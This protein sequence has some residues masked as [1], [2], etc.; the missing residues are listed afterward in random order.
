MSEGDLKELQDEDVDLGVRRRVEYEDDEDGT[1]AL[2]IPKREGGGEIEIPLQ[3]HARTVFERT[4]GSLQDNTMLAVRPLAEVGR[5]RPV[6]RSGVTTNTGIATAML[7]P[8]YLYVFLDNRLWRELE[9]GTDGKLSDVDLEHYR[10]LA[11][12]GDTPNE[13]DSAGEWLDNILLPA[14]LQGQATLHRVR[15]AYSE[16]AWS[17]PYITWLEANPGRLETRTTAVGHAHAVVLDM[18][19]WLSMQTGFPAGRVADQPEL[20][21]RDLGVELMLQAPESF[22]P[23]FTAPPGSELCAKLKTLWEQ[24]GETDR[25]ATLALE[26]EA[27]EDLLAAIRNNAGIVAVA[28]PDPLFT[29]R[30]AL[31]QIHLAEH[32]LDGL[33]SRLADNPLGHSAKLI[34][35]ALF[36]APSSGEANPLAEFR[37]AIDPTKL[38][39]TLEQAERNAALAVVRTQLEALE[40]LASQGQLTAMLRDFTSHHEL[41]ICEGYALCGDLYGVLQ[42]LPGVLHDQGDTRQEAR[43]RQLLKTLLTDRE[44]Q[45]LWSADENEATDE[46]ADDATN[47]GSGNFRPA[48]LRRL[49][50]DDRD[51]DEALAA[52]LGLETLGLVAQNLAEQEQAQQAGVLSV[53]NAI[54]VGGLVNTVVGQWS[55]A[56]LRVA[57][58]VGDD[59]EVIQ[60]HRT[61]ASVGTHAN[62][63]DGNLGGELQVM[64]RG[65]VDL[66]RYTIIGVHGDGIEWG[67]TDR[68]RTSGIFQTQRDYLYA[69]Q[70]DPRG[71]V[72][73]STSPKRM[74]AA[75]DDAIRQVAGYTLV[76]V[77]PAGHPEAAKVAHLRL[78]KVAGQVKVVV[79]GPAVSRLLVG[80][81][82]YNLGS[83]ILN[84]NKAE[85][86]G[87]LALHR[88]KLGSA[89]A[90]LGAATMKLHAVL[91]PHSISMTGRFIQRPWFDMKSWP[92]IGPRLAKVGASTIVRTLGLANFLAGAIAVGISSWELRNSL[93]QGDRDAGIGHGVAIAGGVLFLT[94]PLMAG[95]VMIP[96]WGWALLGLGL[97]IGGSSYAAMNQDTP[98]EQLLKQGP[99]GTHPDSATTST[100]DTAYYPQLLTQLSPAQI[101][102]SR[103]GSLG[104]EERQALLESVWE[105]SSDTPSSRDYV[106]TIST[107][108][109]S[110]YKIGETLNLAVQE[111]EQTD[112][113][114]ITPLGTY[115]QLSHI[116]R[117]PEPFEI[118]KRQLLPQQSAVRFL[119]KRKVAE[120]SFQM[121]GT[122]VTSTARLRVALQ[123]RIEWELGE[124]VL[125][126]PMLKEYEPFM[127]G[128]HD[129]LPA[130]SYRTVNNPIAD[131]ISSLTGRSQDPH[132]WYIKEFQV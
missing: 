8:G 16:I 111:L 101:E 74:S 67:L 109:I 69:E 42:Q 107:P 45:A 58:R 22:T 35:Q 34:R 124:M 70:V 93:Q 6:Q 116:T 94:A 19:G 27:G 30:H 50:Q 75:A 122:S 110:R 4:D 76:F 117:A 73:A 115:E 104:A 43:T 15:L 95:L 102:V 98:F 63:I 37:G 33:D 90:D 32:Y 71:D 53:A 12:G 3:E 118:G 55:Q 114:T 31:A 61:F 25:A 77:L 81:A 99:L 24:A 62:L 92:L 126:T 87:Y 131:F 89:I 7:R 44:L 60:L 47:D 108:L 105:S 130:R 66:S 56:V 129:A 54:K 127:E 68:D 59:L 18:E 83:E 97:A 125:P 11:E 57:E 82:I 36:T 17:W 113:G 121:G 29:L 2:V 48:F 14:M 28:L 20:R 84:A 80:F 88:V 91:K 64:R 49:A 46:P 65:D 120:E 13:R 96:G 21:E 79:D 132:Y 128:Q 78:A 103:Y 100:D 23:A 86:E 26:C 41:G 39:A 40:R 106:V 72:Q 9:V 1:L 10:E 119:V 38:D 123:A 5:N 51:I 85:R 52:S 112:T